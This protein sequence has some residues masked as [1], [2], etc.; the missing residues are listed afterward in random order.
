MFAIAD[1]I[2]KTNTDPVGLLYERYGK[3]LYGYAVS[4]W[5]VSE[6]DAWEL[7]Y[8][9]LYKVITVIDK[10]TFEDEQKFTGFLFKVFINYLRNH[11]RDHKKD[12]QTTE[13]ME[14]HEKMSSDRSAGNEERVSPLMACLQKA[15]ALLD[16][17]Q[18]VLL[19]MRAQDHPYEAIAPYV[20][21][22]AS[23]LKV[24]HLRL[25]KVVSDRTNECMDNK[26]K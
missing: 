7:V 14:K 4:K 3:K 6:D 5:K 1:E 21:R 8:K 15:L 12:I 22:P 18:R 23:Q 13:L 10:Y 16:D 9:T 24:Y 25:K 17:W 19:L 20:D 11:Y 2:K 26:K